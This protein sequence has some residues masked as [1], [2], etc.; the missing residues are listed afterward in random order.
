[1][2]ERFPPRYNCPSK[3]GLNQGS[4]RGRK[5]ACGQRLMES[6][7]STWLGGLALLASCGFSA[8]CSNAQLEARIDEVFSRSRSATWENG[9][10][11]PW[12]AG[13]WVL[14]RLT[15]TGSETLFRL[16]GGPTRGYVELRITGQEGS[17]FWLERHEVWPQ[18]E[19]R[20]AVLVDRT[21]PSDLR[22]A[23]ILRVKVWDNEGKEVEADRNEAEGSGAADALEEG[24]SLLRKLGFLGARGYPRDTSVPAG[25]FRDVH[26]LPISMNL[27]TGRATGH[28]WH[29]NAVPIISYARLEATIQSFI[30]LEETTVEELVDF[31][32]GTGG[33][34]LP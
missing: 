20:T 24:K 27:K 25:T 9:K 19:S 32:Q 17:A 7:V 30:V 8:S 16:F 11:V 28:I 33:S 15:S 31:G 13:Q 5:R 4:E 22:Q 6:A 34:A 14:L 26:A 29:T 3:F 12:K 1:M 18:R 23:R 10:A 21:G 2:A